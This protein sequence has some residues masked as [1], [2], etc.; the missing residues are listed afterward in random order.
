MKNAP[1]VAQKT[2]TSAV[3]IL[4]NK[5]KMSRPRSYKRL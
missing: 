3:R 5:M 4:Q 2:K 1:R